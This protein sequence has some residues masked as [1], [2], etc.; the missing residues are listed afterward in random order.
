MARPGYTPINITDVLNEFNT[1]QQDPIYS[2]NSLTFNTG[3]LTNTPAWQIN[4]EIN[5]KTLELNQFPADL[6]PHHFTILQGRPTS[7]AGAI[8]INGGYQGFRYAYKLPMPG[9]IQDYNSVQYDHN[10]NWLGILGS[11]FGGAGGPASTIGRVAGGL[12][13]AV[14]TFK[15]VTLSVPEFRTFQ[16]EW[17]LY[18]KTYEESRRIQKLITSL[19]RGMTPPTSGDYISGQSSFVYL[20]PDIFLCYFTT[21]QNSAEG[22]KYLF[23][24]KPAVLQ[25]IIANYQGG[26]PVP[27]FYKNPENQAIPE[28]IVIQTNWLELELWRRQNYD[29]ALSSD[30]TY[31]NDPFSA[32]G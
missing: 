1:R 4:Q 6:P 25:T 18:P 19:K 16:L 29:N 11:L 9:T 15:S 20:F 27:A 24:F 13:F 21:G 5:N 12:G 2:A 7:F 3:Q 32:I 31:N 17:K 23:K 22:S 10:F 8:G 14:N 26:G 28:G 30:G